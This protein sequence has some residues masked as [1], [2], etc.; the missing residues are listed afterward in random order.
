MRDAGIS[1]FVT[2]AARR[3]ECAA[4]W[5]GSENADDLIVSEKP[6]LGRT[7]NDLKSFSKLAGKVRFVPDTDAQ[8]FAIAP[9]R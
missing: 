3:E 6:F 2:N 9:L 7:T 1:V 5:N 8:H 4:L